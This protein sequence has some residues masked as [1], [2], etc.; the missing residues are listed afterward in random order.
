[1]NDIKDIRKDPE[2]YRQSQRNR[3]QD[4]GLID[5]LLIEDEYVRARKTAADQAQSKRNKLTAEYGRLVG[6][7]KKGETTYFD[8]EYDLTRGI[9]WGLAILE[10]EQ[11]LVDLDEHIA[12]TDARVVYL[13]KLEER[14]FG[15]IKEAL[16]D[17]FDKI[18]DQQTP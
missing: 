15:K 11:Y 7:Q 8:K 9:E 16:G 2:K 6:L 4:P 13:T 17:D 3:G 12:K 18:E 14:I 10:Y 5:E 1:M